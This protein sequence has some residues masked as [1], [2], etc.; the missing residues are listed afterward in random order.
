MRTIADKIDKKKIRNIYGIPRGGLVPAVYLSHLLGLPI[1]IEPTGKET[2][3]VD[4]ICDTGK[5][6]GAYQ[7]FGYT[8]ATLYYHKQSPV[9]PNI[10]I[11]EK[12]D[13]WI[14]FPWE[15]E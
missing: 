5:T 9:E 1:V 7:H 3:V 8:T 13:Q 11:Y 10:W 15:C 4:D 14:Q 6:L 2:L 12:K